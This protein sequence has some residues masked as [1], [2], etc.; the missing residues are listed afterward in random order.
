[1]CSNNQNFK[2][3][4][5]SKQVFLQSLMKNIN[6]LQSFTH[7]IIDQA[8]ERDRFSDILMATVLIHKQGP[9]LSILNPKLILLSANI[10]TNRLAEYFQITN[11]IQIQNQPSAPFTEYF[12]EDLLM[13]TDFMKKSHGRNNTSIYDQLISQAWF[14]GSENAFADFMNLVT[15]EKLPVNYQ[16]SQTGVSMLMAAAFHGKLDFVKNIISSGGDPTLKVSFFLQ[17]SCT[18]FG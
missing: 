3:T 4:F 18:K 12:L 15:S 14:N 8:H 9:N 1:M 5:C 16:H 6:Y 7:L 17:I 10:N 13:S 11:I 2:I